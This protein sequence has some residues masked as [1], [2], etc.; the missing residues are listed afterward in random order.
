MTPEEDKAIFEQQQ[1]MLK[2]LAEKHNS[3]LS[4]KDKVISDQQKKLTQSE[5]EKRVAKIHSEFKGFK[6]DDQMSVDFLDGYVKALDDTKNISAKKEHGGV[7]IP[8]IES[9]T[10][11]KGWV[12][13]NYTDLEA[14]GAQL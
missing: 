8:P 10:K 14:G 13:K 3:A 11:K 5:S 6:Y 12:V 2:D 1:K 9:A 4:E 7:P